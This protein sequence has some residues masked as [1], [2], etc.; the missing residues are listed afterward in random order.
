MKQI[1]LFLVISLPNIYAAAQSCNE[2]SVLAISG[3]WKK[4]KD[5][6]MRPNKNMA[7]ITSRIDKISK[8]FQEAYPIPRGAEAEWYRTMQEFPLAEGAPIAYDFNSLYKYWYCNKNVDKLL[9]SGETG[10]WG[11]VYVNS[12]KGILSDQYDMLKVKF[13][14]HDIYALPNPQE[15][16]QGLPMYGG[17]GSRSIL[18]T[19][20]NK[21]PWK[22]I[23]RDQ[24]L[25]ALKA[26]WQN[27]KKK[28]VDGYAKVIEGRKKDIKEWQ[29]KKEVPAASKD[30]IVSG[31]KKDLE[32]WENMQKPQQEK[33]FKYWDEKIAVIDNYLADS[34]SGLQKPARIERTSEQFDN[35]TGAFAEEGK[36]NLLVILDPYYFDKQLPD[37]VPQLMVLNWRWEGNAA[38][39]FYKKS[40]EENFPGEKLRAMIDK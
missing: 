4:S 24:Y 6:N 19:H 9:L 28:T 22:P 38:G 16:W 7:Q 2:D 26:Q 40:I 17:D 20:K 14:G 23:T 11:F 33:I 3:K 35:F 21:V 27:E 15:E 30:E 5:A 12:L 37:Y 32:Q 31:L 39:L 25:Q 29:D 13:N 34:L 1:L 8:M 18:I 10:N 36:G